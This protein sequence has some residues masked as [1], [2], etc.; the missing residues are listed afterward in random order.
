MSKS[1][2]ITA[3]GNIDTSTKIKLP[4]NLITSCKFGEIHTSKHLKFNEL[5]IFTNPNLLYEYVLNGDDYCTQGDLLYKNI[6]FPNIILS[7]FEINQ[8]Q[9]A[10]SWQ[11]PNVENHFRKMCVYELKDIPDNKYDI[12]Y[13]NIN[14]ISLADIEQESIKINFVPLMN[15]IAIINNYLDNTKYLTGVNVNNHLC[16]L[17]ICNNNSFIFDYELGGQWNISDAI[18]DIGQFASD[19]SIDLA[20]LDSIVLKSCLSL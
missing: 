7:P 14:T 15:H 1:I 16:S 19:N 10:W 9:K 11:R 20:G 18:N 8:P 4:I 2:V 13:N 5:S 17:T 3:H 12:S 6:E